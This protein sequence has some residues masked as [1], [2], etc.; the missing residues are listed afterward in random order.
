MPFPI[1]VIGIGNPSRGDDALGPLLV[2]RLEAL[3]L[4][5]VELL[6]DFQ[7]QVEYALDLQER[8]EVVFVDASLDAPAPF[9]FTPA[10]AAADA[11]YS[12]HELSPAAVL[13]AY[14]KLFGEPPPAFV[15]AIRGEAFEL[16]EDLSAAAS[17]NLEAALAF[18]TQRFSDTSP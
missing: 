2:E 3:Q 9:T 11:S 14:E 8:Q 5:D 17:A 7:L 18:I 16:G 10:V 6:T 12:S 4:P 15:L 1:L 13:H